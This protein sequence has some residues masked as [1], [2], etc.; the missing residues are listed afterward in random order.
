[1]EGRDTTIQS[2]TI[3]RKKKELKWNTKEFDKLQRRP[4]EQKVIGIEDK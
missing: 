4:E 1:L 2:I 3:A